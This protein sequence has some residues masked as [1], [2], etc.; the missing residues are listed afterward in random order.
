VDALI[1]HVHLTYLADPK[2]IS[3]MAVMIVTIVAAS[4]IGYDTMVSKNMPKR[5]KWA[6]FMLSLSMVSLAVFAGL[7][8]YDALLDLEFLSQTPGAV[9]TISQRT[10]FLEAPFLGVS[11]TKFVFIIIFSKAL[12][13]KKPPTQ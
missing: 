1:D 5:W 2:A 6:M 9:T 8:F 12:Y 13:A 7:R 10:W 3:S 11:I 4:F